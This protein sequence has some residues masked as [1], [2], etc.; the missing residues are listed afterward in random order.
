M[1]FETSKNLEKIAN[2]IKCKDILIKFTMAKEIN[3]L[4]KLIIS[5]KEQENAKSNNIH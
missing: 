4:A 1:E 5:I 3:E 2:K